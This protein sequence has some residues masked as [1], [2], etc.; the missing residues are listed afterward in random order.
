MVHKITGEIGSGIKYW[1]WYK[2]RLKARKYK[3]RLPLLFILFHVSIHG[4]I[5]KIIFFWRFSEENFNNSSKYENIM[6]CTLHTSEMKHTVKVLSHTVV[7]ICRS[8]GR[9]HYCCRY[10]CWLTLSFACMSAPLSSSAVA[11]SV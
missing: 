8:T 11:V 6:L 2:I 10:K 5:I 1:K 9:S 7:M 3:N 4:K